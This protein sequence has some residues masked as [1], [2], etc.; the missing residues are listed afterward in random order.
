MEYFVT[1]YNYLVLVLAKYI[2]KNNLGDGD[3]FINLFKVEGA[4][5]KNKRKKGTR[6]NLYLINIFEGYWKIIYVNGA[7]TQKKYLSY[8]IPAIYKNDRT[9]VQFGS[10]MFVKKVLNNLLEDDKMMKE[11]EEISTDSKAEQ[12]AYSN[13]TKLKNGINCNDWWLK[14]A[15]EYKKNLFMSSD[16]MRV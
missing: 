13:S 5:D 4:K 14:N 9:A 6:N 16:T 11:F 1:D 2:S 10:V 8:S 7:T 12:V 15:T 3:N